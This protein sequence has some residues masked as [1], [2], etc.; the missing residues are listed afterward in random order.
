MKRSRLALTTKEKR[1][2][3]EFS[4]KWPKKSQQE[5]A[6]HFATAWKKAIKSRTVGDILHYTNK[7]M[8]DLSE[9]AL[10]RKRH[11]PAK[12][13]HME[14][15]LFL[16]FTSVRARN[17]PITQDILRNKVKFFG[18]E[19]G[20]G[21]KFHYSKGWLNRF[22]Y[23]YGEIAGVN[24]DVIKSGI[25]KAQEII[26]N[27][28]PRDVY[29]MD[30]TGLFFAISPD[31]SLITSEFVNGTKKLKNRISLAVCANADG[32]EKSQQLVRANDQDASGTLMLLSMLTTGQTRRLG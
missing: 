30:E 9:S 1:E 28:Y 12:H 25:E 16:S 24:P 23:R 19:L 5:I 20:V 6:D 18:K 29:N 11:R 17:I 14:K 26:R 31:R 21:S 4:K 13:E 22:K 3:C 27:Y 2:I 7:C 15:T 32:S 10:T 8:A